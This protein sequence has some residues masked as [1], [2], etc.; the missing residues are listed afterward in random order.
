MPRD[1]HHVPVSCVGLTPLDLLLLLGLGSYGSQTAFRGSLSPRYQLVTPTGQ[2][3]RAV[4]S[5]GSF[6]PPKARCCHPA[7]S[8]NFTSVATTT[9][10]DSKPPV[11]PR[12]SWSLE[13]G[14]HPCGLGNPQ[15]GQELLK[16]TLTQTA[17][18]LE[19]RQEP[20]SPSYLYQLYNFKVL[21]S[22]L[23]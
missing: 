5:T 14:V 4:A 17:F 8:T 12:S 13:G 16:I 10:D 20:H 6:S 21:A 11:T 1:T 15:A 19:I 7:A 18:N 3:G 2:E 9:C 22:V 23:R